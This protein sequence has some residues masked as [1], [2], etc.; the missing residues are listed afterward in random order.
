MGDRRFVRASCV[1]SI[2]QTRHG[3]DRRWPC[4]CRHVALPACWLLCRRRGR[5]TGTRAP[6]SPTVDKRLW[7]QTAAKRPGARCILLPITR[8]LF[9]KKAEKQVNKKHFYLLSSRMCIYPQ[10]WG[11]AAPG[12][13]S[14]RA[15]R[16]AGR[17]A[18]FSVILY[19]LIIPGGELQSTAA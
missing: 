4:L 3:F 11:W 8:A 15:R 7:H 10:A 19:G 18:G 2:E 17:Q 5:Q 14:R 9:Y 6:I 16:L 12:H 1:V 13:A